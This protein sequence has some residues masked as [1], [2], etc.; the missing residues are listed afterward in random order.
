MTNFLQFIEED[1]QSKKTLLSAMPT[2]TKTNKRKYNEKIDT[3]S[4]K[5]E[6]YRVSIK[7]YLDLKSKS[8]NI[9]DTR[10]ASEINE[11]VA[12]LENIK[13]ILNPTNG[14]FE[15]MGFD[16]LLYQMSNYQ[17]LKFSSLK[18]IINSLLDKFDMAA[19][20]PLKEDFDYTYY[21][22]EFMSSF[23]DIRHSG[24]NN[25][26][27]LT[28]TFEKIYWESPELIKHLELNFRKLIRKNE[29]KFSDYISKLQED[30]KVR[31]GINYE[32]CLEKIL[33]AYRELNSL[34][35]EN[36]SDVIELAKDG[37]IDMN[38]Y[39]EDSK[40]RTTTF[41]NLMIDPL[42]MGDETSLNKFYD[43]IEKLKSNVE[44][45]ANY[46]KFSPL[47]ND[48]KNRYLK[49]TNKDSSD[50]SKGKGKKT[51]ALKEIETKIIA[52]EKK[53][54]KLNKK[55]INHKF[56]IFNKKGNNQK[57]AKFESIKIASE[58]S[59]MYDTYSEEYFKEEILSKVNET[60]TVTD[61]L[62][63]YYSF[64]F[65]KKT[66]I[67][68]VYEVNNYDEIVK[69][70]DSFD[71]F[72]MNPTNVIVCAAALYNEENIARV[73]INKYRLLNIN[74]TEE[75]LNP[76]DLNSFLDKLKLILRV[77]EIENS[78]TSVEKIW[79]I[80]EVNKIDIANSKE[81]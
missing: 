58:L 75:D 50:Q 56:L 27:Q 49:Q 55:V 24:S 32:S 2:S 12:S 42:N 39:F 46:V 44:E 35:K 47:I 45:F 65:Y 6:E 29:K 66:A 76:E 63:L 62:H 11:K 70:S 61:L 4:E 57:D 17:D 41:S 64:D 5:Y 26:D 18:D 14:Y 72:S 59:V 38:N 10:N 19:A 68:R 81:E 33:V 13:F 1:V 3:F 21:I 16:T 52:A 51:S 23:L 25:Y 34:C 36:I 28:E 37:T 78:S 22:N 9:N 40:V 67:K 15:K 8:F 30:I 54:S 80:R 79:F 7:K 31:S 43:N 77:R 74:L 20:R 60:F 48:F 69:Y 53:L 71:L 73:I